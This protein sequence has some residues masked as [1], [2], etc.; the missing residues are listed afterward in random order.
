MTYIAYDVIIL[1]EEKKTIIQRPKLS[2]NIPF[3]A[4]TKKLN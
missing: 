2:K 3:G 1:E 4:V